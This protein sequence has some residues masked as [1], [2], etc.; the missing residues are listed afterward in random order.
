M[1]LRQVQGR[2]DKIEIL[3][4]LQDVASV[5]LKLNWL[6]PSHLEITYRQPASV[7]FEAT[8]C[9]GIEISVRNLPSTTSGRE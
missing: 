7:D 6:S 1:T 9:G 8:K 2:Q 4:L 5:D 3:Q